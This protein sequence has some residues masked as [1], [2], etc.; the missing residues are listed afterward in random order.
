[1]LCWTGPLKE[2]IKQR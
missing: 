1:M 2:R